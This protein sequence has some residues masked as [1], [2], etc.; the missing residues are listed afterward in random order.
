MIIKFNTRYSI[1][2]EN[3]PKYEISEVLIGGCLYTDVLE[4]YEY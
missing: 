4:Y 1:D 2:V 3:N